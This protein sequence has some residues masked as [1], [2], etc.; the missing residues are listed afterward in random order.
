MSY[1]AN[2]PRAEASRRNGAKSRGPVTADGKA[3]ASKNALKHGMCAT[4]T[5]VLE[6]ED[7][8]AFEQLDQG[9]RA[10]LQPSGPLENLLAS[11]LAI[12]A[13]RM[14]RADRI[15]ADLLASVPGGH[16]STLGEKVARDRH[17]P[18]AIDCLIRYPRLDPVRV[19]ARSRGAARHP[20]PARGKYAERHAL[21][22]SPVRRARRNRT[23][24][25]SRS[26]TPSPARNQ[27]NPKVA[28]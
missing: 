26:M 12:A 14:G 6:G 20:K 21:C 7:G 4:S 19:L 9:L 2:N 5:V 18:Q 25:R 8:T 28:D 13:W 15:E 3:R 11:R 24:S 16:A 1:L 17:G 10:D 27:T 22:R 23:I